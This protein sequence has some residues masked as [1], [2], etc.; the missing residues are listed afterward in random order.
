MLLRRSGVQCFGLRFLVIFRVSY[1]GIEAS[2]RRTG[3]SMSFGVHSLL[4]ENC[5]GTRWGFCVRTL[6]PKPYAERE[7]DDLGC[8]RILKSWAVVLARL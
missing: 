5:T 4:Y 2:A 7:V 8:R 6:N 3:F 1:Q